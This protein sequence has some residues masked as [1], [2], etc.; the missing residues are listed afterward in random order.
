MRAQV[1]WR[2]AAIGL[3]ASLAAALAGLV[4]SGW[5]DAPFAFPPPLGMAFDLYGV[6]GVACAVWC[7]RHRRLDRRTRQAWGLIA[8]AYTLLV[9]SNILRPFY[10]AGT[11]FPAPPDL[12]R[13][14]FAPVL[15]TGLL[16]LPMRTQGRRERQKVWL[17]TAVVVLA[18]GM[19]LWYLQI[20]PGVAIGGGA[21]AAVIAYPAADLVLIFGAATVLFR[22]A[23]DSTRKPATLLGA[24]MLA[25]VVGDATLGY[26]LSRVAEANPSQWQFMCWLTGHFLLTQAAFTQRRQAGR[27]ELRTEQPRPRAAGRLPYVA[28]GLGYLL[29]LVAV[30]GLPP[31]IIGLVVGALGITVVVVLR[32]VL[33]LQENHELAIT[34]VLTGLSN[35]R[36]LHDMVRLGLARSA[37]NGET[38]AV[39]VLDLNGFKQVNDTMGHE[40]GDRLL[41]AFSRVLRRNVLGLDTVGRLGGDEFAV[42]LHD[43]KHLDNARSVVDRIVADLEAPVL[44]GD[45][46]VQLRASI[47]I[48]LG[49]PGELG[50][51]QLLHHA[52]LAMYRAKAAATT[53]YAH[54]DP[55]LDAPASAQV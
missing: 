14:L 45:V 30:R 53:N 41:V 49:A 28:I 47:G 36:H 18:S 15:L 37:R 5:G 1:G 44:I 23:A 55:S 9:V 20:G 3:F 24:A 31:R 27:H 51:D 25:I 40:A 29:L 34:D 19:L 42:L 12:F 11:A 17:D 54:F 52:D 16:W 32:Q 22:G 7:W 2:V 21:L 26:Q 39:L 35:R 8:V 33:T 10:P 46:P 13:L 48:A 50:A 6:I 4:V 38:V 43:I